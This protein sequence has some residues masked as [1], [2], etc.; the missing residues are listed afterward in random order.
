MV[1]HH[2]REA[3]AEVGLEVFCIASDGEP[4]EEDPMHECQGR[5]VSEDVEAEETEDTM[6]SDIK[7]M[8]RNSSEGGD[9][10]R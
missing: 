7:A 4:S 8:Q 2:R 10:R 3:E 9:C 1:N 6:E 5:V